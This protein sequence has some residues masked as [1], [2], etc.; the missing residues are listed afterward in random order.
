MVAPDIVDDLNCAEEP[1]FTAIP[2]G[3]FSTCTPVAEMVDASPTDSSLLKTVFKQYGHTRVQ[4]QR[5]NEY[6]EVRDKQFD[7]TVCVYIPIRV[8]I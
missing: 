3:Q 2:M 1:S 4:F 7:G 6:Y 5:L 8:V